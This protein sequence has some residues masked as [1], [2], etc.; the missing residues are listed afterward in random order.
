MLSDVLNSICG[1]LK[2]KLL[3]KKLKILFTKKEK[4]LLTKKEAIENVTAL[5]ANPR[6]SCQKQV[7]KSEDMLS[8][9]L[10][11]YIQT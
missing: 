2:K 6:C 9:Y 8:A 5:S 7:L 10:C 3:T 4:I 11:T 1:K